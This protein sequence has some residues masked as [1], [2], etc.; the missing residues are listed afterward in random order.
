MELAEALTLPPKTNIP[1]ILLH[2]YDKRGVHVVSGK[3]CVTIYNVSDSIQQNYSQL[4]VFHDVSQHSNLEDNCP[5]LVQSSVTS[6]G[7][8]GVYL[9]KYKEYVSIQCDEYAI[10]K[11][12]NKMEQITTNNTT[13]G[14]PYTLGDLQ[15]YFGKAYVDTRQKMSMVDGVNPQQAH[16]AALAFLEFIP[17]AWFGEKLLP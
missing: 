14:P 6:N 9:N 4:R 8:K 2:V 5:Y 10:F 13:D 12:K 3:K 1:S 15:S 7:L 16:E 11:P 17:K